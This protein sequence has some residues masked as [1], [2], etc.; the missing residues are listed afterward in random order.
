MTHWPRHIL[1]RT[2]K[3]VLQL[4]AEQRVEVYKAIRRAARP[5]ADYFVM[6]GLAAAIAAFGLLLNS[7]AVIIGAML[8][9]PLMAAIVG[10]GM[11]IMICGC[12]GWRPAPRCAGC[13]W[14]SP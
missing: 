13:C 11:G 14:R 10:L 8:V 2:S 7:P 4:N 12:F 3:W 5:D 1:D 9:A 6:I